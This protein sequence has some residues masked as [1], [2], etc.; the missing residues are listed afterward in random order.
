VRSKILKFFPH[1]LILVRCKILQL[2]VQKEKLSEKLLFA[3]KM[4]V[5]SAFLRNK[6]GLGILGVH[7]FFI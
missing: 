6:K 2:D 3:M 5:L 4:A 1:I 7:L